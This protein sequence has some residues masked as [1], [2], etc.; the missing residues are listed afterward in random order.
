[1]K[2]IVEARRKGQKCP[3][4]RNLWAIEE[5]DGRFRIMGQVTSHDDFQVRLG[6]GVG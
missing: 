1:M 3:S 2:R 6:R 5:N 4:M